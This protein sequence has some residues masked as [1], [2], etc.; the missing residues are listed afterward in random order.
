MLDFLGN[1][2]S[3]LITIIVVAGF[4]AIAAFLVFEIGAMF[5]MW[6]KHALSDSTGE[7][8]TTIPTRRPRIHRSRFKRLR[9]RH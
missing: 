3:V 8:T 4:L 9:D 5:V 2:S 7:R 1:A 6:R